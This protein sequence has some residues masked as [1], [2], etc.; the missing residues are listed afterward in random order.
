MFM[1]LKF[2]R[3]NFFKYIGLAHHFPH[4]NQV[5]LNFFFLFLLSFFNFLSFP[6]FDLIFHHSIFHYV[7]HIYVNHSFFVKSIHIGL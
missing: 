7:T 5:S 4:F 3:W 1:F 2:F 6:F